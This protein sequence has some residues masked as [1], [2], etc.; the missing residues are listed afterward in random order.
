LTFG[1][2]SL[3]ILKR[4]DNPRFDTI[5]VFCD[6]ENFKFING[7]E[8]MLTTNKGLFCEV[9]NAKTDSEAYSG[10]YSVKLNEQSPYGFTVSLKGITTC[11]T[12]LVSAYTKYNKGNALIVAS[13]T[14]SKTLYLTQTVSDT[15]N[16]AAWK[17][18]EMKI[19]IPQNLPH[20]LNFYV[21]NLS[22][23]LVLFD[24]FQIRRIV[25]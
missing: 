25:P 22:D 1:N 12:I 2:D 14:D 23:K 10:K 18:L 4:I 11:E 15:L 17:Y 21:W 5:T 19:H 6:A 9:K 3:F 20:E 16:S 7:N 24:D 13:S 8:Y